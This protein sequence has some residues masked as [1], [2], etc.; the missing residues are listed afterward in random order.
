MMKCSH[1][2][3]GDKEWTELILWAFSPPGAGL[4][5]SCLSMLTLGV[6]VPNVRSEIY[7]NNVCVPYCAVSAR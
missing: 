1:L 2:G 4:N 7:S 3:L 5:V 6:G